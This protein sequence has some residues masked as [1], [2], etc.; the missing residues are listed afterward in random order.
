MGERRGLFAADK[1]ATFSF[2]FCIIVIQVGDD[3]RNGSMI[4]YC[5]YFGHCLLA[6]ED[7]AF[8]AENG[9]SPAKYKHLSKPQKGSIFGVA[10]EFWLRRTA[11]V[12]AD[13]R[14]G[15]AAC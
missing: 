3:D 4:E 12:R 9:H 15:R 10:I 7:E 6:G 8:D 2:E 5:E 14:G 11:L 1:I 13:R